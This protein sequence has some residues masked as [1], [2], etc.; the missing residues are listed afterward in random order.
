VL[1]DEQ[2]KEKVLTAKPL[3]VEPY[4][5]I[6]DYLIGSDKMDSAG[7]PQESPEAGLQQII[8]LIYLASSLDSGSEAS[9]QKEC[10]QLIKALQGEGLKDRRK[11][12]MEEIHVLEAAKDSE[13]LAAKLKEYRDLTLG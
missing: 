8:D 7:S 10:D 12:L 5:Q 3:L 6:L 9:R 4:P 11:K 1:Q 13:A 2:C